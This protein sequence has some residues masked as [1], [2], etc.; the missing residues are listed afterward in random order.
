VT[1]PD[2]RI[3]MPDAMRP[4][5]EVLLRG[6]AVAVGELPGLDDGSRLVLVRRLIREGV[7][8]VVRTPPG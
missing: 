4:A 7:L 2:R 3:V 6:S 1:L 5:V 8:K